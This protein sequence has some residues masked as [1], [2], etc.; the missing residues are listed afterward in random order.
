M[1]DIT[2]ASAVRNAREAGKRLARR[3]SQTVGLKDAAVRI[4]PMTTALVDT[5][6]GKVFGIIAK[7]FG[8]SFSRLLQNDRRLVIYSFHEVLEQ[9]WVQRL[10]RV[11]RLLDKEQK[12]EANR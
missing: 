9:I 11:R 7:A 3:F 4:I 8:E 12:E 1:A 5:I 10:L 2:A 6:G